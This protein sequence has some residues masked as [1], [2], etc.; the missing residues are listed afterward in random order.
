MCSCLVK[1]SWGYDFH[2]ISN[3]CSYISYCLKC[4]LLFVAIIRSHYLRRIPCEMNTVRSMEQL[5]S[6]L[7][8]EL[9]LVSV[10]KQNT[11]S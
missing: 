6:I 4:S 1:Q 7:E 3:F 8:L 10:R 9:E 2:K 5:M 11:A